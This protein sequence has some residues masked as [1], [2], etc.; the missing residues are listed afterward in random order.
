M[1]GGLKTRNFPIL[2]NLNGVLRPGTCTLLM[3]P[4]G[5]GK[6]VFLQALSGRLCSGGDSNVRVRRH[7][8]QMVAYLHLHPTY[9][10]CL[11]RF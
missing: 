6:S 4:P 2:K 3:G 11:P 5:A 10:P 9:L 7:W 8:L 1:Q